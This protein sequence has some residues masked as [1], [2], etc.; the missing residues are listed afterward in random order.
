MTHPESKIADG[1]F[2]VRDAEVVRDESLPAVIG[3]PQESVHTSE[4]RRRF[5]RVRVRFARER[6]E[7]HRENAEPA[8]GNTSARKQ[9]LRKAFRASTRERMSAIRVLHCEWLVTSM[10]KVYR[11]VY[12][13]IYIYISYVYY[14]SLLYCI[15]YYAIMLYC[16]MEYVTCNT[17]MTYI[18]LY[19]V[20]YI[21]FYI[22][23]RVCYII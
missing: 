6:H 19:V 3:V 18:I 2:S 21:I 4:S 15:L 1:W 20:C 14:V 11:Y 9:H 17:K 23:S 22:I 12:I 16:I 13:Y 5:R 8:F 10:Q 7:Q